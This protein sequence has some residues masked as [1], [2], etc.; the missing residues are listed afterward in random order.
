MLLKMHSFPRQFLMFVRSLSRDFSCP[1]LCFLPPAPA[2]MNGRARC[3][4]RIYRY[5]GGSY[6][7]QGS[8]YQVSLGWEQLLRG[9]VSCGALHASTALFKHGAPSDCRFSDLIKNVR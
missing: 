4:Y 1:L 9:F 6:D 5:A 2:T 7:D 8:W 3:L